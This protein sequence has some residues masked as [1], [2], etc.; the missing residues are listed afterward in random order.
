MTIGSALGGLAG[1]AVAGVCTASSGVCAL[2][3]PK[4]VGFFASGGAA[5]GGLLG[6]VLEQRRSG[7]SLKKEWEEIHGIPW[8]TGCVAHHTCP[9][10][11]GGEDSGEN[12][13]PLSPGDHV[14][15]H[16]KKGDFKRWGERAKKRT[17]DEP[18]PDDPNTEPPQQE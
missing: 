1:L 9:L 4:L 16:K 6:E 17:K 7:R 12:I 14:E 5:L 10:A 2:G 3:A 18:K 11:D 13:E 15:H 8:P